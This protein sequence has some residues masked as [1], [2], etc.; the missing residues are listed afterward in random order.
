MDSGQFFIQKAARSV[1]GSTKS[2]ASV[3][4]MFVRNIMPVC[5]CI[6]VSAS[7]ASNVSGPR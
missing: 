7:S 4:W 5:S 3:S 6:G 1:A 2:I